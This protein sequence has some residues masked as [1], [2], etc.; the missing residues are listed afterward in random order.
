MRYLYSLLPLLFNRFQVNR[1]VADG[2]VDGA[3]VTRAEAGPGDGGGGGVGFDGEDGMLAVDEVEFEKRRALLLLRAELTPRRTSAA[4]TGREWEVEE[5][6]NRLRRGQGRAAIVEHAGLGKTETLALYCQH[7]ASVYRG[8]MYWLGAGSIAELRRGL[9]VLAR[10]L[11]LGRIT[12]DAHAH[13]ASAGDMD[14][15][16]VTRITTALDAT[17]Q[18]WLLCV[19]G[20]DAEEVVQ[21]LGTHFFPAWRTFGGNVIVTSRVLSCNLWLPLGIKQPLEL[22][23]LL[24]TDS[25]VLLLRLAR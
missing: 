12:F 22:E 23:F 10:G 24:T 25:S 21:R 14:H 20:A 11:G 19:D 16:L 5:L 1:D 18:K 15:E 2:A 7:R 4:M 8:G 9:A 13:A 17:G 6:D 3:V